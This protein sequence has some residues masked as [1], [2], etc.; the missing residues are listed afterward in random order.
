MCIGFFELFDVAS[1]VVIHVNNVG[2]LFS[3]VL[4]AGVTHVEAKGDQNSSNNKKLSEK[5]AQFAH[6][7]SD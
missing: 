3:C 5:P 2:F 6:G 1:Q 7:I 4:Y